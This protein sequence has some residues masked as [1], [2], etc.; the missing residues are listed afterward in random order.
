M[1]S[2]PNVVFSNSDAFV[3]SNPP[4]SFNY[5]LMTASVKKH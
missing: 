3:L 2:E 4:F 5:I 1:F